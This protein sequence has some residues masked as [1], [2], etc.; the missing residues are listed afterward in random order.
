MCPETLTRPDG[1][2]VRRIRLPAQ[3][4]TDNPDGPY[5]YELSDTTMWC[6]TAY[7]PPGTPD[8]PEEPHKDEMRRKREFDPRKWRHK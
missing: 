5:C 3:N 4:A 6:P 7:R 1:T 2:N 8:P